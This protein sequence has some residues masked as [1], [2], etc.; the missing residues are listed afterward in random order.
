MLHENS[1]PEE[2]GLGAAVGVMIG[3]SPFYGLHT[4]IAL[5]AA[6]LVRKANKI[7]ILIGIQISLP[8][9]M[10]LIYFAEYK[11]GK[12]LLLSDGSYAERF[13]DTDLSLFS[14]FNTRFWAL[15]AGSFVAGMILSALTYFLTV[16][17][18]RR[19]R[20]RRCSPAPATL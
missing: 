10:P 7:A 3:L 17:L 1:T 18:V 5:V 14:Q 13:N 9:L 19:Y 16:W 6:I 11:I 8:P 12:V 20:A 4:V 2:I 15:L